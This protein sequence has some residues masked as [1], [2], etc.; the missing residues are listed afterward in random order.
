MYQ[1][2]KQKIK[3]QRIHLASTRNLLIKQ[4]KLR[5]EIIGFVSHS[6]EQLNHVLQQENFSIGPINLLRKKL[7]ADQH[8]Y[9]ECKVLIQ[10]FQNEIKS[11]KK[12]IEALKLKLS[13]M[14]SPKKTAGFFRGKNDD[15]QSSNPSPQPT[16][17]PI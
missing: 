9:D 10:E 15:G 13:R 2:I 4:Q 8:L 1:E 17:G 11:T 3:Q 7:A 16:H 12:V 14:Y 6:E 5:V